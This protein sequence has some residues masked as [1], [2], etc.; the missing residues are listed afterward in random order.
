MKY[1]YLKVI[2]EE[3]AEGGF[4]MFLSDF[5]YFS[6]KCFLFTAIGWVVFFSVAQTAGTMFIEQLPSLCE[7]I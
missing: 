7:K 1:P 3:V 5:L 6:L 4:A 2:H